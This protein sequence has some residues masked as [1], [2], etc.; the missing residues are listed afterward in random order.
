LVRT[1]ASAWTSP[2]VLGERL[3]FEFD[4]PPSNSKI[5]VAFGTGE[6]NWSCVGRRCLQVPTTQ[7]TMSIDDDLAYIVQHE[8]GHAICLQ[9]E[10]QYPDPGGIQ[11]NEK[12][13]I[14]DCYSLYGWSEKKTRNNILNKL[15]DPSARC[16]GDKN[17][18][19]VSI[20]LYMIPPEWTTDGF[21]SGTNTQ[22]TDRDIKCVRG[23]YSL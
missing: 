20:M 14:A 10:Q 8:F 9:H 17:F 19:P 11:W 13:V 1:A 18:N 3:A 4:A 2:S 16:I 15:K 21:S 22:I 23:V 5:R 12:R 7:H 6:G